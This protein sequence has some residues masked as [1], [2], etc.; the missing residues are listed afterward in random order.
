MKLETIVETALED[1]EVKNLFNIKYFT[2]E[3]E[4]HRFVR[5]L[6]EHGVSEELNP[7]IDNMLDIP[8]FTD[9]I[10][11]NYQVLRKAIERT[12]QDVVPEQAQEFVSVFD[13]KFSNFLQKYNQKIKEAD[14]L[15]R[16]LISKVT[17]EFDPRG[18]IEPYLKNMYNEI[19]TTVKGFLGAKNLAINLRKDSPFLKREK[20]QQLGKIN[21]DGDVF[22]TVFLDY[23]RTKIQDDEKANKD[24][25]RI[26]EAVKKSLTLAETN[27][28]LKFK[29]LKENNTL[30]FYS[31]KDYPYIIE[32]DRNDSGRELGIM[33]SIEEHVADFASADVVRKLY[34]SV[35]DYYFGIQIPIITDDGIR[36]GNIEVDALDVD[37]P[38][39]ILGDS[40][41]KQAC[42]KY[43]NY[44]NEERPVIRKGTVELL[45]KPE[46]QDRK[47]LIE[48]AYGQE[49]SDDPYERLSV[50]GSA[51]LTRTEWNQILLDAGL[52]NPFRSKLIESDGILKYEI[53]KLEK[54][55]Y[56]EFFFMEN[57]PVRAY[58]IKAAQHLADLIAPALT[59]TSKYY[60]VRQAASEDLVTT[61]ETKTQKFY[62]TIAHRLGNQITAIKGGIINRMKR[63]GD[64]LFPEI[65]NVMPLMN[66]A[67]DYADELF[68]VVKTKNL[69]EEDLKK[70]SDKL[71]EIKNKIEKAYNSIEKPA[72]LLE[73]LILE[74][75][76]GF[77]AM[78]RTLKLF[79]PKGYSTRKIYETLEEHI[80]DDHYLGVSGIETKGNRSEI[81]VT[82]KYNLLDEVYNIIL[83]NSREAII[84]KRKQES[85]YNGVIE[86]GVNEF[87]KEH[88]KLYFQDNG[89]GIPKELD[90]FDGGT[91][92]KSGHGIGLSL[93]RYLVSEL[94]G[95]ID[96]GNRK[97]YQGTI[98]EIILPKKPTYDVFDGRF[99]R[100]DKVFSN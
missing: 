82:T 96:I 100:I 72:S 18:N 21:P 69:D 71:D 57:R 4:L 55:V 86:Y 43:T 88:V 22:K 32:R 61:I 23:D 77:E 62:E 39:L 59:I 14:E 49:A 75:I 90:V 41:I 84:E 28:D 66:E 9:D 81:E 17:T 80:K 10:H 42:K 36:I 50:H 6:R 67:S 5:E 58:N 56:D 33:D 95:K 7:Y 63:Q 83:E 68:N 93:A 29:P 26:E 70:Y 1:K 60:E 35:S 76:N 52:K 19:S 78:Q 54:Q 89:T 51:L 37:L 3:N 11:G 16:K 97:D 87:D 30:F 2:H 44:K 40:L 34:S 98:V 8:F 45:K 64:K 25:D 24:L 53:G 92:K 79:E 13:E 99:T 74:A 48:K 31:G 91:T 46:N 94:D 12:V 38:K 27:R 85:S 20:I 73:E 47:D 15:G 65:R